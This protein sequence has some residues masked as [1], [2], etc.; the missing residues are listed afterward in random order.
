VLCEVEFRL[1]EDDPSARSSAPA[2]EWS[3]EFTPQDRGRSRVLGRRSRR[4]MKDTKDDFAS[5]MRR[6][7]A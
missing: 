5:E 2:V 7:V 3:A 4:S 6:Q 1:V